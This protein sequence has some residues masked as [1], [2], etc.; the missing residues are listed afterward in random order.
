MKP[1][2]SHGWSAEIVREIDGHD[3]IEITA[4]KGAVTTRIA[5]LYSSENGGAIIPH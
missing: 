4:E 5:V 2:H 3:C 1:L